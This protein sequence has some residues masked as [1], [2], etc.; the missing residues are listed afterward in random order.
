MVRAG[1]VGDPPREEGAEVINVIMEP[2]WTDRVVALTSVAT[3]LILMAAGWIAGRQASEARHLRR[4]QARPF[5]IIDFDLNVHPFI[6][7]RI[8]NS[9]T[10][11]ARNIR[12]EISP[13]LESTYD[14]KKTAIG[15][16]LLFTQGIPSLPPGNEIRFFFDSGVDRKD[17]GLPDRYDV[18]ITYEGERLKPFLRKARRE[19][20]TQDTTM[21]L[22]ISWD[23]TFIQRRGLH[24]IH[25]RLQEIAK[26]LKKRD[27]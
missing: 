14:G 19:R 4:A 1:V 10:T 3:V 5:V 22:G 12:F 17:S 6:D 27:Q 25:E 8:W 11:M 16:L 24:D 9:G 26:E 18:K 7:V 20:F 15:D 2:L 23:I 13:K 21:D